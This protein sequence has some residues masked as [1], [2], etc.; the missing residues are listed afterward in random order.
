MAMMYFF[1]RE[2]LNNPDNT[3]ILEAAWAN[4]AKQQA[5]HTPRSAL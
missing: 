1:P 4:D 5:R 3:L 2:D